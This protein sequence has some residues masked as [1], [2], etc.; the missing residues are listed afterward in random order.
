MN[1]KSSMGLFGK[2]KIILRDKELLALQAKLQGA[3]FWAQ[4][5]FDVAAALTDAEINSGYSSFTSPDSATPERVAMGHNTAIVRVKKVLKNDL[6]KIVND[7]SD[8]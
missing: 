3:L 4:K 7:I 5:A 8:D 1:A 6:Q 2:K